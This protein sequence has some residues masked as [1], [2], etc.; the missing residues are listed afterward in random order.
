MSHNHQKR[1]GEPLKF[2]FIEAAQANL[3]KNERKDDEFF[4]G[5]PIMM[6]DLTKRA[7][8]GPGVRGA[9]TTKSPGGDVDKNALTPLLD[10]PKADQA[11]TRRS[12]GLGF[13]DKSKL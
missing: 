8:P 11:I 1:N 3:K 6:P 7:K 9:S 4:S 10:Q 5:E 2:D 12:G 13:F